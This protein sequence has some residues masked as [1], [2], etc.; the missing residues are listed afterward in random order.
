MSVVTLSFCTEAVI[1]DT[2]FR[3]CV[4]SVQVYFVENN[5]LLF[6]SRKTTAVDLAV[7]KL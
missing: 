2:V 3:L 4:V 5:T 6:K 1:P 7:S